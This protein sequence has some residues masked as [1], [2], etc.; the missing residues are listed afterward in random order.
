M[1]AIIALHI[2]VCVL[3]ISIILVQA[4]RGGGLVEGFTGVESMFGTKTNA[5]LTRTTTVLSIMFFLSCVSLAF[6]SSRQSKSLLRNAVPAAKEATT[7]RIPSLPEATNQTTQQQPQAPS[8]TPP[9][10][11]PQT[12]Q[13]NSQQNAPEQKNPEGESAPK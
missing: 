2:F 12:P 10:T 9:Q 13:A 11:P 8:Q 5:F 4:G 1:G 7:T 3:L 6:L